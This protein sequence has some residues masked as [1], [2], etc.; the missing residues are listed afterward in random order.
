MRLILA[1]L[2]ATA[3]AD[4]A[5]AEPGGL[6]GA[7]DRQRQDLATQQ[8]EARREMER[9]QG[10]LQQQQERNLQY[11]LLLRQQPPSPPS[12]RPCAQVSGT[13]VCQ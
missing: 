9:Q 6:T 11:Q 13:F 2:L 12:P 4:S 1:V 10:N 3:L 8:G 5:S 7:I